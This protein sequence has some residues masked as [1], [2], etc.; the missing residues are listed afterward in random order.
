M[1]EALT[2]C[3]KVKEK[4]AEKK[5]KEL[6]RKDLLDFSFS[7]KNIGGF[8]FFPVKK[9]IK[10][11][12]KAKLEK[13]K[14][15]PKSLV[16]ALQQIGIKSNEVIK[17]FDIIGDIA[18]VVIPAGLR[19]YEKKIAK[20]VMDVH[21]NIKT[22]VKKAGPISGT[23][24]IRKIKVIGG[25]KSTETIYTESGCRFKLDVAKA[26][27]SPRLVFERQRIAEMV[28]DHETVFVPFAGVGPFAIIIAKRHPYVTVYANELNPTAFKYMKEN[29]KLNRAF[30]VT[31]LPGDAR[32]FS[33]KFKGKA[34]RVLMPIPMSANKFLD[35]AFNLAKKNA[36]VH[37]YFFTES[38][39]NAVKAIEDYAEK[40]GKK[41]KIMDIREAGAYSSMIIEYV[42]D[43]QILN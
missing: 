40:I 37:F 10:G 15:K 21:P 23:Y 9:M 31:P 22:V 2:Y 34:D 36:L 27:F 4:D 13:R 19:K 8:V 41:V 17:S 32:K 12:V 5:R 14:I 26:Y 3:T 38:E 24:R 39:E 18:I 7:P 28:K 35:V 16:E 33:K 42:I 43:F 30:N 20:A 29:I 11:A 1:A 6:Q 25:R